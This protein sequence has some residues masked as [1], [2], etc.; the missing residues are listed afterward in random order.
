ME[1]LHIPDSDEEQIKVEEYCDDSYI[2]PEHKRALIDKIKE[3]YKNMYPWAD[4]V[5]FKCLVRHHYKEC[6]SKMNKE[7]Y[8]KE[9]QS[10]NIDD[11]I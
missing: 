6:V 4:D 10:D 11:Y 9:I 3:I 7:E 5:L 2:L 8:L 1:I